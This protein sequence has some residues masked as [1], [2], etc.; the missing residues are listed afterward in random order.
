MAAPPIADE[1][2]LVGQLINRVD[3]PPIERSDL[4]QKWGVNDRISLV[5]LTATQIERVRD[6]VQA[7]WA[8]MSVEARAV[9]E[10]RRL[11][12]T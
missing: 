6:V 11:A 3:L 4:R 1:S 12:P 7:N 8:S 2:K 9:A 5:G 10:Y